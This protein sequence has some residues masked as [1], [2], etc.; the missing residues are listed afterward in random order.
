MKSFA[1]RHK[2]LLIVF[3]ILLLLYVLIPVL[4]LWA[5]PFHIFNLDADEISFIEVTHWD[6]TISYDDPELIHEIVD[7]LNR[8]TYRYWLIPIPRGGSDYILRIYSGSNM[9]GYVV[10]EN[11]VHSGWITFGADM[12][13]VSTDVIPY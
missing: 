7:K 13:F 9:D 10:G 2:K 4:Y 1:Y 5:P 8:T 12:A 3:G 6:Q 11:F